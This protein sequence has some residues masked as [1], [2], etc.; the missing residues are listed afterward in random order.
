MVVNC[1]DLIIGQDKNDIA[2]SPNKAEVDV[3]RVIDS[4]KDLSKEQKR[5]LKD[6]VFFL[7]KKHFCKQDGHFNIETICDALKNCDDY[8]FK[9]SLPYGKMK[10]LFADA[11]LQYAK[12]GM[13]WKVVNPIFHE[14]NL[15]QYFGE[16]LLKKADVKNAMCDIVKTVF[17]HYTIRETKK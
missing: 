2:I 1:D 15:A 9:G 16:A 10:G 5:L 7:T 6:A 4:L 3:K 17:P 13:D 14:S 12:L 8:E 11:V